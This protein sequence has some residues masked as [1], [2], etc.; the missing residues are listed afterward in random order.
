MSNIT[1]ITDITEQKLGDD[2]LSNGTNIS[3]LL[4]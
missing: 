1:D 2:F 3:C 4:E